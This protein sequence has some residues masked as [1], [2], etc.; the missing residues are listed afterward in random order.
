MTCCEF[1]MNMLCFVDL[2]VMLCWN[3]QMLRDGPFD[4]LIVIYTV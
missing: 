3:L 1:C 2:V 4:F